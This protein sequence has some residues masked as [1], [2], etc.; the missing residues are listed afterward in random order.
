M[1]EPSKRSPTRTASEDHN[2]DGNEVTHSQPPLKSPLMAAILSSVQAAAR[3]EVCVTVVVQ[4][5][6]ASGSLQLPRSSSGISPGDVV[7]GSGEFSHALIIVQWSDSQYRL[8][9]S[10]GRLGVTYAIPMVSFTG[11]QNVCPN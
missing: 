7:M 3:E 11:I 9:P 1:S 10:Q 2:Q 4:V 6:R 5:P 8:A